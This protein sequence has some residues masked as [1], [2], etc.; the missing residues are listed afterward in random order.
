MIATMGE[1]SNPFTGGIIFL[2]KFKYISVESFM[3]VKGCLYQSIDGTKLNKHLTRII[4]KY[5]SKRLLIAYI[6]FVSHS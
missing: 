5:I 2:N 4:Q 3:N 6:K 1:K